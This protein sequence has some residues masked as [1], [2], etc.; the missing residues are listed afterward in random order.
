MKDMEALADL[1]E[2]AKQRVQPEHVVFPREWWLVMLS[3]LAWGLF[4]EMAERH[5]G[6]AHA[7]FMTW[8]AV[9]MVW[10]AVDML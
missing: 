4:W 6:N 1:L 5:Q 7:Q 2:R 8:L 9:L 3:L 10:L